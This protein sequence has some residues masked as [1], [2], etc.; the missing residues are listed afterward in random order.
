MRIG[1]NPLSWSNDD[2]PT[3]GGN[4]SLEQCLREGKEVGYEGFEL[5]NKFPREPEV[6]ASIL[7]SHQLTLASGWFSGA[8]IDNSV[9]Q[10]IERLKPHCELLHRCGSKVL[11]YCDTS[12]ST[13]NN[14][15]VSISMRRMLTEQQW[16]EF[17]DKLDQVASWCA[18]QQLPMAYHY[19][20][21]TMVQTAD[22]VDRLMANSTHIGLLLDTGHAAF[23]GNN[24]LKLAQQYVRRIRHVH[25]K[26][27]RMPIMQSLVNRD[28]SF[29]E[30]ILAGVFTVPGDGDLPLAEIISILVA[31]GYDDWLIVEAEQD[32]AVAPS[33][34]MVTSAFQFIE[35]QLHKLDTM[36]AAS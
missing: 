18:Q 14:P 22:E 31:G 24:P 30:A 7:A 33:I 20:M 10:E 29:I 6:L 13:Q 11:I 35:S 9:E 15:H 25:L 5:G 12:D 26:D 8:I 2:L 4:T 27:V 36:R 32:P 23:A 16:P 34:P 17:C 1:V 19:H 28:V 21:G 3:L